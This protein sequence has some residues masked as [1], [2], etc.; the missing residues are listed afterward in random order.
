MPEAAAKS[1]AHLLASRL[2]VDGPTARDSSLS[3]E[4]AETAATAAGG[5][6]STDESYIFGRRCAELGFPQ[7][8][9]P[10]G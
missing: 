3:N 4:A 10:F 1:Q 8:V 2:L 9:P 5:Y 7:Y 6:V